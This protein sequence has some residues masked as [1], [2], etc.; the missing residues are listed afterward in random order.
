MPADFLAA[1]RDDI[2]EFESGSGDENI[3][4]R[5]VQGRREQAEEVAANEM[6]LNKELESEEESDEE[7]DEES[8]EEFDEES[9]NKSDDKSDEESDEESDD[10]SDDESEQNNKARVGLTATCSTI[11]ARKK[12]VRILNGKTIV[13][14]QRWGID[15]IFTT[16]TFH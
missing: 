7:F 16:L 4:G 5:I 6:F 14:K 10:K 11:H 3:Q 15:R 9:D 2:E 12:L 8:V 13:P 1:L